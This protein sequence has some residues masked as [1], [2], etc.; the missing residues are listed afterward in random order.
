MLCEKH[1][2]MLAYG[3]V[4][5]NGICVYIWRC[6]DGRYNQEQLGADREADPKQVKLCEK[7]LPLIK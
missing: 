3:E 2:A 5:L 6:M 4:L 1:G 7:I